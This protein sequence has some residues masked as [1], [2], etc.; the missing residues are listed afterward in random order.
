M[1]YLP[2]PSLVRR[3]N[4]GKSPSALA[5]ALSICHPTRSPVHCPGWGTRCDLAKLV[6][7]LQPQQPPHENIEPARNI[8]ALLPFPICP[9]HKS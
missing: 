6:C 8:L 5:S 7:R 3:E 4:K 2:A 1:L 9:R